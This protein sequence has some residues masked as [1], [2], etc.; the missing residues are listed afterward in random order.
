MDFRNRLQR[1]PASTLRL[2][3]SAKKLDAL[4]VTK[5]LNV[6]QSGTGRWLER[7]ADKLLCVRYRE[8]PKTGKRITTV[9][10][11]VEER[12]PKDSVRLLIEIKFEEGGLR[13]RVKDH[14]GQWDQSRQLWHLPYRA[15]EALGLQ[16]RIIG[17]LPLVE[18]T[19]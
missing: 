10:I 12:A 13:Q 16:D 15:I 11:I 5:R 7:F 2:K 19:R 18:T 3:E 6:G 14:G 8:D 1:T 9:E 17:K 4:R